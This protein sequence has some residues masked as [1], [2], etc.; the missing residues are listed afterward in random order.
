MA[1]SEGT[2]KALAE[3]SIDLRADIGYIKSAV[4]T[5]FSLVKDAV[6]VVLNGPVYVLSIKL[7]RSNM[8]FC[9]VFHNVRYCDISFIY[10]HTIPFLVGSAVDVLKTSVSFRYISASRSNCRPCDVTVKLILTVS[11]SQLGGVKFPILDVLALA[12]IREDRM[13]Y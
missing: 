7:P 5:L 2:L 12:D 1:L 3:L 10:V 11:K 6:S 9:G 4:R 8:I 13:R